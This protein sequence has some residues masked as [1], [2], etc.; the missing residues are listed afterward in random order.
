ME[1]KYKIFY[2]SCSKKGVKATDIILSKNQ[3]V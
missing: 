1:L 3:S 2:S